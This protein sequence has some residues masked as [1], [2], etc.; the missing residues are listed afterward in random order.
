MPIVYGTFDFY[1]S[2]GIELEKGQERK[3]RAQP[4]MQLFALLST[5]WVG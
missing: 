5:M 2:P 1:F 4:D 3:Q